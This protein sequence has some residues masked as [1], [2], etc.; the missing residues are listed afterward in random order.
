MT[1]EQNLKLLFIKDPVLASKLKCISVQNSHITKYPAKNGLPNAKIKIKE[2]EIFIH[3][4]YDPLKESASAI[5]YQS[6]L[7]NDIV[8]ILGF[9]YGYHILRLA[10]LLKPEQTLIIVEKD[11]TL[12]RSALEDLDLT[13]L[14]E[15]GNIHFCVDSAGVEVLTILRKFSRKITGPKICVENYGPVVNIYPDYYKEIV[16]MVEGELTDYLQRHFLSTIPEKFTSDTSILLINCPIRLN[17]PPKH[18]PYGLGILAAILEKEG[19]HVRILDINALRRPLAEIEEWLKRNNQWDIIGVSGLITTYKYQKELIP[20]LRRTNPQAKIIAGGGC[21]TSVPDLVFEHMDIDMAVLG[22]GEITLPELIKA[23][24]AGRDLKDIKGIWYRESGKILK[25]EAREIIADLDTIPFPARHLL[26]L[27]R[28]FEN[29]AIYFGPE[30]MNAK[31]RLD[32]ITTRGCP[33]NCKFCYHL[34]GRSNIR[35][36]SPENVV[37]E[38]E[39]LIKDYNMDF[40]SVLDENFTASKERVYRFTELIKERNIKINWGTS[41]R[42]HNIDR[43]LLRVMKEAGCVYLSYGVESGSQEMLDRMNK[44]ATVEQAKRALTLTKEAGIQEVATFIFGYPGETRETIRQTVRFC[45]EVNIQKSF[46]IATPYPGTPLF[47]EVKHK[48]PDMDKFVEELSDAAKFIINLTD[49]NTAE[50]L[51]LKYLAENWMIEHI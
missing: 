7:E 45:Q 37:E 23:L 28:Y 46:F 35:Y 10:Q 36:R 31:R 41:S 5:D 43:K 27:D 44:K 25:N 48:I 32:L 15:M 9:G 2:K 47:E 51:G 19:Y 39:M 21:V 11:L 40:I 50:L 1:F 14:F 8:I 22:E 29:S 6:C 12:F 38:I 24:A 42:V 49:F 16:R 3:S 34:F 17:E 4:S 26:P 13:V 18:I 20:I 33:F 30:A